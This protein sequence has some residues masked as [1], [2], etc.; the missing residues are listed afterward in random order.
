MKGQVGL[1]EAAEVPLGKLLLELRR[2]PRDP[3]NVVRGRV[4][5]N[6][7]RKAGLDD[8]PYLEDLP[9]LVRIHRVHREPAIEFV[10]E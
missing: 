10:A 5:R 3:R 2:K 6:R 9:G 7:R 8:A 4:R 1:I